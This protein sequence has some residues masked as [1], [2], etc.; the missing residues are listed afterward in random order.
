MLRSMAS[1]GRRLGPVQDDTDL[2]IPIVPAPAVATISQL[3]DA[4]TR[5]TWDRNP[6]AMGVVPE[7]GR[8]H[9]R[10]HLHQEIQG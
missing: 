3:A 4:M 1:A 8:D 9:A 5:Q 7:R 2:H 6:D 10:R